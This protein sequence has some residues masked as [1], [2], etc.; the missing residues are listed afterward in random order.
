MIGV[1]KNTLWKSL[2]DVFCPHYCCN[3]GVFG[4]IICSKCKN[5]IVENLPEICIVCGEMLENMSCGCSGVFDRVWYLGFRDEAVGLMAEA[6]KFNSI[7]AAGVELAEMLVSMVTSEHNM[8]VVPMPTAIKHVRERGLD[9]ALCIAKYMARL[10]KWKVERIVGRSKDSVQTGKSRKVRERQAKETFY[11][12]G[13][14]DAS[15]SYLILDDI[16]T[17]GASVR[18]AAELLRAAGA[19]KVSLAV[20]A[21][22]R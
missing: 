19:T 18:A 22:S 8:V 13:E 21:R 11:L 6:Y 16:Y 7:R 5:Y 4:G 17:T 14:V 12:S 1:V 15:K 2:G 3:C 10:K 9:H 20:I